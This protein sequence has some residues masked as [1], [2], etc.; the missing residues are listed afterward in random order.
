[1][2]FVALESGIEVVLPA[3]LAG[4]FQVQPDQADRWCIG[5]RPAAAQDDVGTSASSTPSGPRTFTPASS[6]IEITL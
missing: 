4:R 6:S 5:C 1:M 3:A 2:S